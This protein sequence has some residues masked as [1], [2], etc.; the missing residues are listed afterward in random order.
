MIRSAIAKRLV[1]SNSSSSSSTSSSGWSWLCQKTSSSRSSSSLVGQCLNDDD[2]NNKK[3]EF[4]FDGIGKTSKSSSSRWF[5]S[6]SL[7]GGGGLPSSMRAAVFRE[8]NKPLTIEEF[9]IPRPKSGE[10][11]LKT[12]GI[13]YMTSNS[14]VFGF[15]NCYYH[16]FLISL[17]TFQ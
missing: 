3:L 14:L 6:A 2:N 5:H 1:S 8:P 4:E 12:K 17:F 13:L 10:I 16:L 9:H 15:W 11:L 7:G